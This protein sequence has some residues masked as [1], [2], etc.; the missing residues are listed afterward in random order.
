[1][2]TFWRTTLSM[3]VVEP[4]RRTVPIE[5]LPASSFSTSRQSSGLSLPARGPPPSS[6][7][8]FIDT[9]STF[10]DIG[11]I[12]HVNARVRVPFCVQR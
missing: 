9:I 3:M 4:K 2:L 5:S 7:V 1:M 12:N 11:G 10:I 6:L 8:P